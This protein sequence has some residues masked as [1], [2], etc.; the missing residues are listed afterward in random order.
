MS[1]VKE[2]KLQ[3]IIAIRVAMEHQILYMKHQ[4]DEHDRGIHTLG[5]DEFSEIA[6][7][8]YFYESRVDRFQK[9]E[10]EAFGLRDAAN[11][12]AE[13]YPGSAADTLVILEFKDVSYIRFALGGE[14]GCIKNELQDEN[15]DEVKRR[16]LQNDLA[17]YTELY[18]V[19]RTTEAM[20]PKLRQLPQ[21]ALRRKWKF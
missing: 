7:G 6:D 10:K 11:P 8:I 18:D 1:E 12:D 19:F 3:E 16:R 13:P 9:A 5:D 21:I 14:V 20:A 4:L 15:L 2:L 17:L